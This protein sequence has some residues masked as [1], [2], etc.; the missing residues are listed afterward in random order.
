MKTV[1]IASVLI[2][3][4][5]GCNSGANKPTIAKNSTQA[6]EKPISNA[7]ILKLIDS[8]KKELSGKAVTI[9]VSYAAIACSCAQWFETKY[10]NVSFLE[11]VERFYMEPMDAALLNANDLWDGESLPLKLKVTGR[12]SKEKGVPLTHSIKGEP[13]K[14][15]IFWYDKIT[16]LSPSFYKSVKK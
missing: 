11:G 5:M 12:F 7:G 9:T 8:S 3:F 16:V 2:V 13:E 4:V 10:E 14:A 1:L 6:K 15:R